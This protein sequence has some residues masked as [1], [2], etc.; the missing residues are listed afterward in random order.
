MIGRIKAEWDHLRKAVV[1]KPGTEAFFG[2]LN[3]GASLYERPFNLCKA[4][5]EH[6]TMARVLKEDFGVNV[7]YLDEEII[8]A[9]NKH[10]EIKEELQRLASKSLKFE[11]SKD[12]AALE[13]SNY[14]SW[15]RYYGST[16]F[17]DILL[18]QPTVNAFGHMA[19]NA[20]LA[21]AKVAPLSNLY[22][23]RDQQIVSDKGVFMGNMSMPQRKLETEITKLLWKAM[24]IPTIG[25]AHSPATIEGGDFIPMG[26]FAL[27]GMG[28]RTNKFGIKQF[29]SKGCQYDEV[30]VVHRP[31][32]PL[33]QPGSA[34][35]MID[36][37]LDT[38]FNVAGS[39][40]VVGSTELMKQAHVDIYSRIS[41]GKYLMDKQ[42]QDL[43]E[44]TCSKGFNIIDISLI[45]QLSYT[46]NFLC[47]KDSTILA[48]DSKKNMPLVLMDLNNK[49]KAHP[50]TYSMLFNEARREYQKLKA[51]NSV[52]PSGKAVREFGIDSKS[53]DIENLTGGYGGVH[54]MTAAIER[55]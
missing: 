33:I 3:P 32:H 46:S 16:H 40:V 52:F 7:K 25:S 49:A 23:M 31:K 50:G 21:Y 51:N 5:A 41:E 9:A 4:R 20:N 45:E 13:K 42:R 8:N 19:K 55:S 36:M 37:H 30:A 11:G 48:A 22:F 24:N 2:L 39:S 1:H 35:P 54:C 43:Y 26:D 29:L 47:I 44:Y 18:L 34:D 28:S 15:M 14:K 6:D 27:V 17:F 53:I 12:N 10:K 38:Y